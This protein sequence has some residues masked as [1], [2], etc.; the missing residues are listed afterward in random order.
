MLDQQ[1]QKA[2]YQLEHK[3]GVVEKIDKDSSQ[4]ANAMK[5]GTKIVISTLQ[6]FPFILDKIDELRQKKYAVV[7][8]E[9]HSSTAGENM[10][11]LKEVLAGKTPRGS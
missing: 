11:S 2:I 4:L 1:L 3:H 6:K 5:N 10:A 7:I 8:D 9:A